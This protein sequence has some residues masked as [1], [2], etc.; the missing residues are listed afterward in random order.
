MVKGLPPEHMEGFLVVEC[1][2]Q[3]FP[4]ARR[5]IADA[6]RDGGF[7]PLM[8]DPID[9]LAL[10]QRK[11][12]ERQETTGGTTREAAAAGDPAAEPAPPEDA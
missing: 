7:P 10:Y 8:L 4:F 1:A 2:R 5:V 6:S 3:L 12:R 11:L 9:F